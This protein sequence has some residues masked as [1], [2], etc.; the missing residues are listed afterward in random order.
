R[1]LQSEVAHVEDLLAFDLDGAVVDG[2][3]RDLA[4]DRTGDAV[5]REVAADR[6]ATAPVDLP[7]AAD[8]SPDTREPPHLEAA[9]PPAI[10]APVARLQALRLDADPSARH[11]RGVET[12][13]GQ[14]GLEGA[15]EAGGLDPDRVE[16]RA[17]LRRDARSLGHE[18]VARHSHAAH[19][20]VPREVRQ[21][22][23]HHV[24]DAEDDGGS[25][26]SLDHSPASLPL[27][28]S[29]SAGTCPHSSSTSSRT[30]RA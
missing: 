29:C 9:R 21:R 23:R 30:T 25:Q 10:V 15:L 22:R 27:A 16:A 13:A 28:V 8:L 11:D 14:R 1:R 17:R 7:H 24:G 4:L 3:Q 26:Y 18:T 5:E 6:V 2:P 19:L 20:D 12:I